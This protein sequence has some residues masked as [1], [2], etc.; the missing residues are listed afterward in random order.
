MKKPQI[1]NKVNVSALHESECDLKI[2]PHFLK[3][4]LNFFTFLRIWN[5]SL[6]HFFIYFRN[7]R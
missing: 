7:F 2:V 5:K 1:K 6:R 3:I 4:S